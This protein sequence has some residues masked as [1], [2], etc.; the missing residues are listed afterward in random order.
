MTIIFVVE[1]QRGAAVLRPGA[2]P[3]Y[4][5]LGLINAPLASCSLACAI[6]P[7]MRDIAKNAVSQPGGMSSVRRI[8][9]IA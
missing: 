6:Q 3:T 9:A 4:R 5:A 8:T 1:L 7:A 2:G